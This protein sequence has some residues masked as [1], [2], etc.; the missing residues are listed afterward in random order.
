[1]SLF[2]MGNTDRLLNCL[3]GTAGNGKKIHLF[4]FLLHGRG[5][6]NAVGLYNFPLRMQMVGYV[7]VAPT[8]IRINKFNSVYYF[9]E[10]FLIRFKLKY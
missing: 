9:K 7:F 5:V 1:M 3:F 6:V 2:Y 10:H 4:R 8:H